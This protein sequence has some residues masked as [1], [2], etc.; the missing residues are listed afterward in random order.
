M[1]TTPRITR[2]QLKI[3]QNNESVLLGIVS[4]E[5][6]YK[7]SLILNRKLKIALKNIPPVILADKT[8]KETVFSRFSDSKASPGPVYELIS[9]RNSKNFL[10]KKLSNID[11][12]FHI[13]NYDNEVDINNLVSILRDVEC[14]TAVFKIDPVLLKDKNL[15]YVT[16]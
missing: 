11:Y 16:Q 7:L 13:H 15:H 14:V 2:V 3:N 4:T 12:I 10:L 5:P 8:T 6:D 9:N 1:K